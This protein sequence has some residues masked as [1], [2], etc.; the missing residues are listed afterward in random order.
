M[1]TEDQYFNIIENDENGEIISNK[2]E[3]YSQTDTTGGGTQEKETP[4][5]Q[6]QE[7][8]PQQEPVQE[9]V[10]AQQ[11]QQTE[12]GKYK[13][14]SEKLD[15][16][17]QTVNLLVE[18]LSKNDA[19]QAQQSEL[20]NKM[21]DEMAQY[22]KDLYAQL[23]KPFVNET[24][25]LIGD[26]GRMADKLESMDKDKIIKY[27]KGI[28]DDLESMLDNNGVES[29]EDM[30]EKFNPKTQRALQ[31]EFTADKEKD[32]MVA[33]HLRKGYRWRGVMLKPETVKVYKYKEG[34]VAQTADVQ[35]TKTENPAVQEQ[36][37]DN[38][39]KQ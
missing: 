14:L 31:T 27:F 21:Y 18:N 12:D 1:E 13:E 37:A 25:S 16:L 11:P 28:P 26:Y 36:P 23:M 9:P 5:Q 2:R 8:Q 4:V 24:I 20:F 15:T 10:Q 32:N 34:F 30:T 22:K 35:E 3:Y 38:E 39:Q 33:G 19:I 7:P 6:T 29:Y 17:M